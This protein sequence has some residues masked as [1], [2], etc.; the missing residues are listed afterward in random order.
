MET[1]IKPPATLHIANDLLSRG[2][3]KYSINGED[4]LVVSSTAVVAPVMPVYQFNSAGFTAPT[5]SD[6]S[7]ALRLWLPD[8]YLADPVNAKL[9]QRGGV[10]LE[11]LSGRSVGGNASALSGGGV[12]IAEGASIKVD[13]G[14]KVSIASGG[15]INI[16]GRDH[17]PWRRDHRPEHQPVQQ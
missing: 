14:H 6:P 16:D 5:G 4:G 2:F 1:R 8:E 3:S 13:A 9:I 10:D 17:R 15:Q 7:A 11:L 12:T